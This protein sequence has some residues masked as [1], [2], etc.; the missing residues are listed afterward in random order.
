MTLQEA[1]KRA[2]EKSKGKTHT[3]IVIEYDKGDERDYAVCQ[4]SYLYSDEAEAFNTKALSEYYDGE[5][6]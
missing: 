3:Y 5:E 4:E 6:C 2:K 1:I